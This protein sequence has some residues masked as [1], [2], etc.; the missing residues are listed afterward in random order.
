LA[1]YAAS[2]IDQCVKTF[3]FSG[4]EKKVLTDKVAGLLYNDYEHYI[5]FEPSDEEVEYQAI[6][7]ARNILNSCD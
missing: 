4:K 5:E 7:Y 2:A 6:Q 3:D 1:V